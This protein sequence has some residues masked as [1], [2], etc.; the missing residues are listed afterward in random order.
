M[1]ADE[2]HVLG[3]AF[4]TLA[5]TQIQMKVAVEE[6]QKQLEADLGDSGVVSIIR[7]KKRG[8]LVGRETLRHRGS[9]ETKIKKL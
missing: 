9:G 8:V 3:V 6:F 2:R 1:L 5:S 7:A 4:R